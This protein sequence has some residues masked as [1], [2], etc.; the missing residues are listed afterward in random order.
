MNTRSR[1]R[2]LLAAA[3][4]IMLNFNS[5]GKYDDGPGF[6]LRTKTARLVGEWE[7]VKIDNQR[8]DGEFIA[9]FEDDNDLDITYSYTNNGSTYTYS[10]KGEWEW[11]SN[12]ENIEVEI[13]GDFMDWE[14]KRLTNS[15]LWFEDESKIEYEAEKL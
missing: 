9:E 7:I 5:C 12:K 15:E 3:V 10:M 1:K 11:D 8:P 6:S 4:V 13:D 14:V 2:L